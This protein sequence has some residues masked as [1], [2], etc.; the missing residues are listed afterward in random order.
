MN[1]YSCGVLTHDEIESINGCEIL[2][3]HGLM[4]LCEVYLQEV[5][6]E[7]SPS[8]HETSSIGCHVGIHVDFTSILHSLTM[9]VPQV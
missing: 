4:V 8:D 9:L 1:F 6:F 5:V 2:E 3:C 7:N